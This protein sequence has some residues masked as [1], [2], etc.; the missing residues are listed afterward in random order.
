MWTYTSFTLTAITDCGLELSSA[1]PVQGSH[2][3]LMYICSWSFRSLRANWTLASYSVWFNRKKTGRVVTGVPDLPNREG[4][5]VPALLNRG[6][7]EIQL[8]ASLT[9]ED[10]SGHRYTWQRAINRDLSQDERTGAGRCIEATE[11]Q[12]PREFNALD[13]VIPSSSAHAM[14]SAILQLMTR[15]ETSQDAIISCA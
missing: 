8:Q 3:S 11:K 5:S 2:L 10:V 6:A 13:F 7:S 4:S 14:S 9:L 12:R 15:H 1:Q